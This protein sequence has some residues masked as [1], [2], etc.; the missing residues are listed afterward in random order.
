MK[1][2]YTPLPAPKHRI[3]KLHAI[4][5]SKFR[6]FNIPAGKSLVFTP[7]HF[8]PT[9]TSLK[10]TPLS[11]F[12]PSPGLNFAIHNPIPRR[13]LETIWVNRAARI[14]HRRLL[15]NGAVVCAFAAQHT[16]LAPSWEYFLRITM[17]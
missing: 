8:T 11:D 12:I 4:S 3:G 15:K 1:I 2:F 13:V 9:A 5:T 10:T 17:S 16:F 14:P 6:I 7:Q